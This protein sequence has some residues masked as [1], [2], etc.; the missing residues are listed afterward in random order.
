MWAG[1][2][3]GRA[4]DYGLDDPG[5]N[6]GGDENFRPSRPVLGPIQAPVQWVPGLSR[7]GADPN[8]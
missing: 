5:P 1:S 2:S 8:P 3:V 7:G 4:T 6:P